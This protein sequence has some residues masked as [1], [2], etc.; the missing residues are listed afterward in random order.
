MMSTESRIL[1]FL[2]CLL[3]A[4]QPA[5][6][7]LFHDGFIDDPTPSRYSICYNHSCATVVTDSL[8]EDEWQRVTAPLRTPAST[9]AGERAAIARSMALFEA[10]IGSHTGTSLDKGRNVAGFGQPGQLDCIDESTNTT[11]YLR[12]LEQDGLLWH[13]RVAERATRFGLFVGMPHSTAVI[14]ESRSG[15]RYVVDSWFF[16]NGHPPHIVRL[17]DWRAGLDPDRD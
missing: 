13:H 1:P 6:D 12:L 2:L 4:T 5:A 10:V 7:I 16:D 14:E 11:T 8:N 17:E 3:P 9:A 15:N